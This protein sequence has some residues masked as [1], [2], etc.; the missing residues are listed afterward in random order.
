MTLLPEDLEDWEAALATL[1]S[2]QFA[3]WL[4]SGRT[5]AMKLKP[6][7]SRGLWVSVHDEPSSGV[8]VTIPLFAPPQTPSAYRSRG[9]F[10]R[11]GFLFG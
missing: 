7:Q 3:L 2:G 9:W 10:G 11:T 5:P 4:E 6:D 1:E 8:T